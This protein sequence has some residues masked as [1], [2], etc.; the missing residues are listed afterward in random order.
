M[1]HVDDF[2]LF[3]SFLTEVDIG[4]RH[5]FADSLHFR[6]KKEKMRRR[7]DLVGCLNAF[8]SVCRSSGILYLFRFDRLRLKLRYG[9]N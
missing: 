7:F 8:S 9:P 1:F 5:C 6:T 2:G 3:F 4:F